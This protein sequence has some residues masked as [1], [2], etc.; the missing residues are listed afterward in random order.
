MEKKINFSQWEAMGKYN[1]VTKW[2]RPFC[3][4]TLEEKANGSYY[5]RQY[6]GWPIYLILFIPAHILQFFYCAWDGGIKYFEFQG[7][8]I[9]GDMISPKNEAGEIAKNILENKA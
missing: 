3:K 9:N 1:Y 5:R 6:L 7:R 8:Y 2:L 4:Y